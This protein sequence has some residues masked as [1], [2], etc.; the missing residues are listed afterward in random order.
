MRKKNTG[1]SEWRPQAALPVAA[2]QIYCVLATAPTSVLTTGAAGQHMVVG[3]VVRGP[4]GPGSDGFEVR[5]VRGPGSGGSMG[6]G[7]RAGGQL[8]SRG[9][10]GP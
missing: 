9:P 3:A 2:S 7:V 5:G 8:R 10:T 1:T 6:M 4:V